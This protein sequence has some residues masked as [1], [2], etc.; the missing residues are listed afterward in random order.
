MTR[1]THVLIAASGGLA[2]GEI[3]GASQTGRVVI[4]LAAVG[5]NTLPDK[6]RHAARGVD[7]SWTHWL[8]AGVLLA[9][10]EGAL[11]K[12]ISPGSEGWVRLGAITGYWLHLLADSMTPMGCPLFGPFLGPV[13]VLP[14]RIRFVSSRPPGGWRRCP[15]FAV[16]EPFAVALVL[17]LDVLFLL[18]ALHV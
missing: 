6:D 1:P 16:P 2:A 11:A 18:P 3:A 4:L 7:R 8:L 12:Q 9:V 17:G 10:I 15:Y 13:R 5:A 14:F